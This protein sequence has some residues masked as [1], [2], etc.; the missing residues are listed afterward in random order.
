V[1]SEVPY[2]A[3]SKAPPPLPSD[4]PSEMPSG[5]PSIPPSEAPPKVMIEAPSCRSSSTDSDAP[6]R[7]PLHH[8]VQVEVNKILYSNKRWTRMNNPTHG[9]NSYTL[10]K[11]GATVGVKTGK[12]TKQR[13]L[14][15]LKLGS[16]HTAR[17]HM[18]F[19]MLRV[20]G[21]Y[22]QG[23]MSVAARSS[24]TGQRN[25][26][27]NSYECGDTAGPPPTHHL[28]LFFLFSQSQQIPLAPA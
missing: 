13:N 15:A 10:C 12:L 28:Q 1:P 6:P 16:H 20:C 26:E 11:C 2:A 23:T 18:E 24:G 8:A 27:T 4:V 21:H 19:F 9:V 14:D 5:A 25:S 22:Q 17:N 7:A 3:P